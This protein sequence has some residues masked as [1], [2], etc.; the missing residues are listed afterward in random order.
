MNSFTGEH[1]NMT[2]P[3]LASFKCLL[4][5]SQCH[6]KGKTPLQSWLVGVHCG[7]IVLITN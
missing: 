5:I 4:E 2:A 7:G 6:L 1:L 3:A